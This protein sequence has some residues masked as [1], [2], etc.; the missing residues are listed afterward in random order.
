MPMTR[1]CQNCGRETPVYRLFGVLLDGRMAEICSRC[2]STEKARIDV[3]YAPH[4]DGR[5][6]QPSTGRE[7]W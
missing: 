7:V 5:S 4:H 2:T 6:S 3:P 1:R